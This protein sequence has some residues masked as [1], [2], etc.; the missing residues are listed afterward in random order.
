MNASPIA[1]VTKPFILLGIGLV[2]LG[3]LSIYAPQQS[4]MTVGVLDR[5]S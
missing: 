4:G 2:V 3:A 1:K 5:R